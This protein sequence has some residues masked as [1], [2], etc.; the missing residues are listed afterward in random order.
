MSCPSSDIF[1]PIQSRFSPKCRYDK[2]YVMVPGS[3][4]S[5]LCK[6]RK[7]QQVRYVTVRSK[8]VMV[9]AAA[10][11]TCLPDKPLVKSLAERAMYLLVPVVTSVV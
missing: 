3:P 6:R 7:Y 4:G 10:S 1:C 2:G 5:A 9:G 11:P 8:I